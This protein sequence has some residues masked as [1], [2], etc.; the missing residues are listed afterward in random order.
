MTKL[1]KGKRKVKTFQFSL[2]LF[3]FTSVLYILSTTILRSYN[4]N[5]TAQIS[6]MNTEIIELNKEKETLQ[7]EVS[8][9][10][11]YNRVS[12]IVGDE[13][14]YES[15]NFVTVSAGVPNEE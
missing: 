12:A 2:A 13:L 10:G 14:Q 6:R 9:L 11:S 5:L 1:V 7:L 4:V 15:N 8:E 3:I